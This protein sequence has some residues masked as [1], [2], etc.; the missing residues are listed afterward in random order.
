MDS[1]L[2]EKFQNTYNLIFRPHHIKGESKFK[3][4]K[5]KLKKKILGKTN[6]KN[7]D[8]EYILFNYIMELHERHG[9]D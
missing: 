9:Y 3:V 4:K 2:E 7:T 1:K 6:D 8:Y 5:C